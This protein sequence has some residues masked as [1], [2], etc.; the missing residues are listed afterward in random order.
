MTVTWKLRDGL[1]WSDGEP[2]SPATTSSTRG[3]GSWTRTTSASSP[4]ASRT[5]RLG[6][7]V[8]DRHGPPLR[9]TCSRA[10]S[11]WS[12]RPLPRHFLSKIPVADQ[13]KGRAS[14][15]TRSP[16]CPSSGAFKFESVTPGAELRLARNDNYTS[17]EDRQ[18]GPPRLAHVQVVRRPGR[19]DR[20]L[21]QRRG[22]H[23]D[24]PPGL[25][26]CP[27]S[28]TWATRSARS[29]SLTY[30]FLRP[31]WSDVDAFDT[32]TRA[33]A[34]ARKNPAVA[35]RGTGCPMADPAMREAVAYA[36]DKNEINT[37][38]LGGLAQ[39]AN[40]FVSPRRVVLRGPAA[41]DVR[42]GEG[43]SRSSRTAAGPTP[44]ATASARRT[45]SKAKIELC[46]TTRQV[47][48]DTLALD[49]RVAQGRR[50]RHGHQPGRRDRIFAD[51]NES[52]ADTPC[53]LS[54]EQLRPRGARVRAR[55]STRSATTSATTAAS[56]TRS[57]STT[58][59]STTRTSTRPSTR[60]KNSVDFDGHQ[61]RDGRLP[62]ALR[63][64]DRRD[65]ALLPQAGRPA[66]AAARQLLRQPAPRPD[67]TWNV[68]DWFVT[69]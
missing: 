63:R 46:T 21:P 2:T 25:A 24:R 15:P 6:L 44:T 18:A 28:R 62:A 53:V 41:D 64:E 9:A 61:G 19:D 13:V 14:G 26:T 10:T 65:P 35:D 57:A 59:A 54:H 29:R 37:R 30:E 16:R 32:D 58:P 8:R 33:S 60:V 22:R 11:R 7:P 56:S 5:S 12:S 51:Y 52:T 40:T 66:R 50:H 47:R 23:R 69:D 34:A 17:C 55:R 67:P 4:R 36:I 27:R 20:R 48:Q 45:A 39:V 49:R 42:P 1:K 3:S 38:L 43:A 68:V 31:N